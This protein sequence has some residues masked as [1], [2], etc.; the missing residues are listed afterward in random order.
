M[1]SPCEIISVQ[2][3]DFKLHSRIEF[4]EYAEVHDDPS[5]NNIMKSHTRKCLGL[6]TTD[7]IQ[8]YY[9]FLDMNT[10]YKLKK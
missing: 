4:G 3:L 8:G 6:E 5:P 2:K 9:K 10:G 7:N 1:Y